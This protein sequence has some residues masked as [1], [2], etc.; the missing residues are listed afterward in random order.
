MQNERQRILELVEKGTIS[1]QE[2]ITLLEALE[3]PGK[4]TQHVMN[5]VSKETQSFSKEKEPLFEEK[6]KDGDKKKD[7]FM[8]YF[9]DEMQD[10]RKDLTQIGSLF[11][12]MMNTAVKK[13]KEFDVASPF[14]DKI[15]FTHTEEVAAANVDNIIV[16]LPNGNFSLESSE[17]ETI[18]VICKVKAPLMNESEEETRNHFLEQFVVKEEEQSLRILSQLKLVQ[19]NVKVL[20]PKDKLEKLSVRLMNGSVSLQDTEF[21]ELK[22]KTLNGA[23]KGTKFN[24]GKAEVDS[25]NGSIELTNVRGKD[26]EAETL[27]GRVYLDGALDEVEA[28]SVNG[29]VVVT[30]CSTNSSKIKAQTVAGAVELYVPRTISLSGKVVT[31]FGKV[32][33]GIQDVSKMESQDQFLSKVVRFDKEVENANRLFIE[34]ESKTGAVLVRYTTTDEQ[35]I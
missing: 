11:M 31:N 2:A 18:Q 23:I 4:S 7:D 15:E 29:H 14:G 17:G 24:F 13:V 10:F 6:S 16:E 22:V 1:A 32:D 3:Q 34:G 19:V 35:Q 30:T 33:V 27:N 26:L 25:S 28:K 12:D 21:E 20:V 5:D 8:K 9:Q